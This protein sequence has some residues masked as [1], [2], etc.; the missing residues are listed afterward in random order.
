MDRGA[1]SPAQGPRLANVAGG[2]AGVASLDAF[3][4]RSG[5]R[6]CHSTRHHFA[7]GARAAYQC[8]ARVA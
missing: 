4:G 5:K 2:G 8:D 3:T 1:K 6:D 7:N